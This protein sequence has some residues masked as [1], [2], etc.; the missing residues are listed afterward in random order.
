MWQLIYKFFNTQLVL[1]TQF[2]QINL[3]AISIYYK[4][5]MCILITHDISC[6]MNKTSCVGVFVLVNCILANLYYIIVNIS[7][8]Y[9][10]ISKYYFFTI[11]F[12]N[13]DATTQD[14][15]YINTNSFNSHFKICV[16]KFLMKSYLLNKKDF[17][18]II[19]VCR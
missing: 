10:I 16:G 11:V 13:P 7:S 17:S 4:L 15:A 19:F 8:P 5:F 18:V 6:T 1:L 12:F 3:T 2:S 9:T 14:L